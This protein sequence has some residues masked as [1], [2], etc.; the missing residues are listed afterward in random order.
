MRVTR[1]DEKNSVMPRRF[2]E[3]TSGWF[4]DLERRRD[5]W[6]YRDRTLSFLKKYFRMAV[7]VGRLPS[8]LGRE[9]F[10]AHVTSY[11][12]HT[13]EDAAIFV[14][15]VERCLEL[16]NREAQTLLARTVFQSYTQEETAKLLGFERHQVERNLEDV[17]DRM[18]E[19]FLERGLMREDDVS[20]R[21]I[22]RRRLKNR[23]YLQDEVEV[24]V[25]KKK[26]VQSAKYYVKGPRQWTV[27]G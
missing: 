19:I 24:D 15:D 18:T 17:L 22:P 5:A 21:E 4:D 25:R 16:L 6:M 12:V 20:Y 14:T 1:W 7:E 9:I 11:K 13:F 8:I 27:N 2:T 10:R 3:V 26:P 23:Q